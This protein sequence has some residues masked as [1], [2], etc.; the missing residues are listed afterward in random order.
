LLNQLNITKKLLK[1]SNFWNKMLL[2]ILLMEIHLNSHKLK[3]NLLPKNLN[4]TAV[5]SKIIKSNHS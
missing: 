2:V 4:N 5:Y 3:Y 1:S